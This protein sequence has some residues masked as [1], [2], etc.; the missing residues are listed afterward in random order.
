MTLA[1]FTSPALIVPHLHGHD[2][3]AVIQE[4][5]RALHRQNRILDLLLFYHTALNRELMV[6]TDM[7]A[8]MAFPH[9]RLA[10][11]KEL[12]FAFGRSDAP[13]AWGIRLGSAVRL[14][15]LIAVPAT[16]STQH[17]ALISGLTRLAMNSRLVEKLH[18]AQ[19][20]MQVMEVLNQ[21]ELRTGSGPPAVRKE[22]PC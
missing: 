1:D 2:A 19:D 11:L 3:A 16:D 14:V 7:E 15:F 22:T 18:A 8:G 13:L 9:A 12:C 10:T 6:S 5:S 17:L 4:L 20:T 21:V